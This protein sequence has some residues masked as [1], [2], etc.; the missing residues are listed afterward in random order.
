[1]AQT[2]QVFL[3]K[4]EVPTHQERVVHNSSAMPFGVLVTKVNRLGKT[5]EGGI[6]STLRLLNSRMLLTNPPIGRC[7]NNRDRSRKCDQRCN[8]P[9]S[10]AGRENARTSKAVAAVVRQ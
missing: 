9:E 3:S 10:E 7:L 2:G 1:M 8:G 5:D 6:K 4:L